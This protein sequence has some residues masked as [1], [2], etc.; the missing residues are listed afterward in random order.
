MQRWDDSALANELF[1]L[2]LDYD[3]RDLLNLYTEIQF[4]YLSNRVSYVTA[5][6]NYHR[7]PDYS[8]RL[9]YL[10]SLPVFASTSIYSVFAVEE[11]QE[12]MGELTYHFSQP[13]LRAFGRYTREIYQ[14][15]A[16]ANVFEVGVEKIRTDR[17]SG[18]L[19]GIYRDDDDGQ[20]LSG[21][22]VYGAYLFGE[23]LKVGAGAH[24]DVLERRLDEDDETTS[25]RLWTDATVY[26]TK[27]MDVQVKVERTESD[28][29]D[30]YF[31][32]RVRFNVRF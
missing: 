20:D 12:V 21:V 28:L 22:K 13:S 27:K 24:V 4:D 10:Y 2:N 16:D 18:Y 6:A 31:Q 5:G 30:E 9:E 3:Y 26:L 15:Y 29:W 14:E 1:G 32:G 25:L 11:Y 17:C 19:S 23:K 7:T 8:V